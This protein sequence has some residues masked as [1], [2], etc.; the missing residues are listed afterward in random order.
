ME[1]GGVRDAGPSFQE[2]S[3]S[4]LPQHSE[5]LKSRR[6]RSRKACEPCRQRKRKCD[7]HEPCKT[8]VEFEYDCYFASSPKKRAIFRQD[9][10]VAA[11]TSPSQQGQYANAGVEG[12]S[13]GPTPPYAARNEKTYEQPSI[14]D[15]QKIRYMSASSAVAFPRLL[16]LD[17][18]RQKA[19]RLHAFGW[20]V[21]TRR[22]HPLGLWSVADLVSLEDIK[23]L[24]NIYFETVHP[25]LGFLDRDFFE[26]NC[27]TRWAGQG[28]IYYDSVICG[29]AALGSYFS[30]S[31]EGHPQE[32]TL[33]E[34]AK[35]SLVDAPVC[36]ALT[37]AH[38]AAMLL[39][40]IYLR[41]TARPSGAWMATCD[42]M[43]MVEATGLHR[44]TPSI[45]V[46]SPAP[47]DITTHESDYRRRLAWMAF[48]LNTL[49]SYEYGR[50]S[51]YLSFNTQDPD[52]VNASVAFPHDLLKLARLLPSEYGGP[53]TTA[54]TKT[55]ALRSALTDILAVPAST[56]ARLLLKTDF[57]L[58]VYRRLRLLNTILPQS[59]TVAI[60]DLGQNALR[61]AQV[62]IGQSRPW[63]TLANTSFQLLCALLALDTPQTLAIVR[64]TLDVLESVKERWNTH[65]TREALNTARSLID[66]VIHRKKE[67]LQSLKG[68]FEGFGDSMDLQGGLSA[69]GTT[70]SSSEGG[71]GQGEMTFLEWPDFSF[72]WDSLLGPEEPRLSG[73]HPG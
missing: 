9:V 61:A 50:S 5:T 22:E 67:G 58:A 4:P 42:A 12:T 70:A 72:N 62:L 45:T 55:V 27:E 28:D 18:N 65:G 44:C 57:V 19:P 60:A 30:N 24:S 31:P 3:I 33:A 32:Q 8:C 26:A 49:F 40:A 46:V 25:H 59:G 66:M 6:R 68:S 34:F 71:T 73:M 63:W 56:D 39:R 54:E 48:T 16:G 20:H 17:L 15:P 64:D 29:V 52:M 41:C 23:G 2:Q 21:G 53:N 38:V 69:P 7:G 35:S 36:C 13:I 37:T 51:V 11:S 47:P 1:A 10:R 14:L 43:H